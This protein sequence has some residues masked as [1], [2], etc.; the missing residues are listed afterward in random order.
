[1]LDTSSSVGTISEAPSGNTLSS[2][3]SWNTQKPVRSGVV[4]ASELM[5]LNE[6]DRLSSSPAKRVEV[7]RR[8]KSR[9]LSYPVIPQVFSEAASKATPTTMQSLEENGLGEEDSGVSDAPPRREANVL[10]DISSM[11]LNSP[12]LAL[13]GP[14]SLP[15]S[16][17]KTDEITSRARKRMSMPAVA[18]QTTSVTTRP[19]VTGEGAG[20]RFSLVLGGKLRPVTRDAELLHS[21]SSGHGRDL[22]HGIAASRLQQLMERA[23]S[24]QA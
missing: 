15:N 7:I 10:E 13:N 22:Q 9:P 21:A 2:F 23:K 4:K 5:E 17:M 12:S 24:S 1:M 20:K 8:Q 16:P 11:S 18:L 6:Q 3:P 19:K 14:T